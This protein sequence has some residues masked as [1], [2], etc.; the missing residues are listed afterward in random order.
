MPARAGLCGTCAEGFEPGA[1]LQAATAQAPTMTA[2]AVTLRLARI[3]RVEHL[4]VVF[5]LGSAPVP[6]SA[7]RLTTLVPDMA[8]LT[9]GAA[10]EKS[11]AVCPPLL[12]QVRT[13]AISGSSLA[14]T[15][16]L[17][18]RSPVA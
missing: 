2:V 5:S 13:M 10:A 3:D 6:D 14:A 18:T 4:A 8:T 1:E 11:R 7:A 17:A 12:A 16:G 9:S 15:G